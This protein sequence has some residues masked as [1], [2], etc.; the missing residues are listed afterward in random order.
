MIR[1]LIFDYD[2]TIAD[3]FEGSRAAVNRAM[4]RHGY[5][6][7]S[8]EDYADKVSMSALDIVK[9]SMPQEF[10]DDEALVGEA[11]VDFGVAY[12]DTSK[13]TDRTY[14]GIDR[15]IAE[16]RR[17][18]GLKIGVLSNKPEYFLSRMVAQVLPAGDWDGTQG[19]VEG[20]PV[21]PDPYQ[22]SLL[23]AHLGVTA[24]ECIMIGDSDVD[25]LTAKNA[26]MHH[27]AAAW[28]Y[29]PR[30]ILAA[31]GAVNFAADAEELK[32]EILK[33]IKAE[34]TKLC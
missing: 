1:A 2:G 8:R 30:D 13:M 34:E 31:A 9:Y 10:R 20:K 21:K 27:I 11:L 29:V 18:Y 28:G 23:S 7:Q 15:L 22:F 24:R 4:E 16:M 32:K 17:D 12:E 14:P 25:F 3:T 33:I 5:P 26:G 6:V 19:T